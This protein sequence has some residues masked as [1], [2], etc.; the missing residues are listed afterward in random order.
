MLLNT[1]WKVVAFSPAA[2]AAIRARESHGWC[3]CARKGIEGNDG[4]DWGLTSVVCGD[5]PVSVSFDQKDHKCYTTS[6]ESRIDGDTWEAHC[7]S[8][9]SDGYEFEGVKYKWNARDIK[10]K[11][12]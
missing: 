1:I 10:G 4:L 3:F 2:F 12:S 5:F 11:C 8:Y 9:A 7:K 6:G